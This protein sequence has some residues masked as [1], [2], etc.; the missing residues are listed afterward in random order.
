MTGS[1][2]FSPSLIWQSIYIEYLLVLSIILDA[3]INFWTKSMMTA[4][5]E[6]KCYAGGGVKLK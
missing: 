1:R 4:G 3:E 2:K 5:G 6:R